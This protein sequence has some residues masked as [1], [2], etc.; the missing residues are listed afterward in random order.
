MA[1][2]DT[3]PANSDD[4]KWNTKKQ[5]YI[6]TVGGFLAE[7]G[8]NLIQGTITAPVADRL[9]DRLSLQIDNFVLQ[10][11]TGRNGRQW[12]KYKMAK[13][14]EV[15]EALYYAQ[16]AQA[17][18]YLASAGPLLS[19]QTGVSIEKSKSLLLSDIRGHRR[20]SGEA[21]PV[22]EQVGILYVG[23]YPPFP[24]NLARGPYELVT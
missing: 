10:H 8:M 23:N 3:L 13:D 11:A 2:L 7:T 4:F 19:Q 5:R 24:V 6:L 17:E 16:I 22:L 14:D 12:V 20:I 18:Y 21:V 9:L 15:K 1:I